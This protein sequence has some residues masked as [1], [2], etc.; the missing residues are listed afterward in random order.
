MIGGAGTGKTTLLA[1]LC[2]SK[3]IR[4]GGVLLLAPT[5]KARV[6]MIQAMKEHDVSCNAKTVAQFLSESERYD[7]HTMQYKLSDKDAENVPFTVII[8]ESSML[9]EEMMG[10]LLQSLKKKA[11]RIIFVGDPNQLPPIGSG[12]PFVDLV[13]ELSRDIDGFPRVGKGFGELTVNMRQFAGDGEICEDTELAKWYTSNPSDLDDDIFIELQSGHLGDRVVFKKWATPEDLQAK[14]FDTIC[15][16]TGMSDVDDVEKFNVSLGGVIN[17]R[18]MNYGTKPE[19]IEA[20]QILSPYRN[21]AGTGTATINRYIHEKYRFMHGITLPNCQ[22]RST[23]YPLGTDG[24]IYGDKIIN[25][26]NQR[27]VGYPKTE[28]NSYVANGEVGIIESLSYKN[29]EKG[30]KTNSHKVRFSSQPGCVYYWNSVVSEEGNSDLELAYALTVHKSQGSEFDTAI[31]VIGEPSRMI[32]KE[33]LYTAMTRQKSRLVILYNDDA[34][35]LRDYADMSCSEVARRITCLF[36]VPDI[37]EYKGRYYEKSLIHMTL[38]GDLVRSKSEVII[39]NMLYDAGLK[40]YYEYE[41]KLDLGEDGE[42]IPDF[43]IED[44]ETGVCYYWEHC[45]MLGNANYSKRWEEKKRIYEKHGIVEGKNL[46]VTKDSLNGAID[47]TQIK[48]I[49]DFLKEELE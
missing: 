15:N 10:A 32:S 17:G 29:H 48:K 26:R 27:K 16:V 31:L 43:T 14:I 12:R 35:K 5:G 30:I 34:V 37:K 33:L 6:R 38:K 2:K 45:G 49:V 40:D 13:Q 44:A 39:A 11:K 20:W 22:V 9:T 19:L 46:F 25:V 28:E 4:D 41:K 7:G 3:M 36:K 21:D 1:L 18:W 8:D 42:R 47:S 24:I 23:K